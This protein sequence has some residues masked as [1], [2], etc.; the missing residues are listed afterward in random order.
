MPSPGGTSFTITTFA[1][2]VIAWVRLTLDL[3]TSSEGYIP[4][5]DIPSLTISRHVSVISMDAAE[6]AQCLYEKLTPLFSHI[7]TNSLNVSNC[8][9]APV[10]SFSSDAAKCVNIPLIFKYGSSFIFSTISALSLSGSK[11]IRLM[12]VSHFI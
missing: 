11:P 12:P 7:L 8:L 10:L 2:R 4:Y 1:L 9:F 6:L 3:S 5:M